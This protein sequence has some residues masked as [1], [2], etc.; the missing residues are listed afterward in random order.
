ML[1]IITT[2]C[3]VRIPTVAL[4]LVAACSSLASVG[5]GVWA[6]GRDAV[7]ELVWRWMG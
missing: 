1:E 6:L 4:A 3:T 7:R 2:T 5:V